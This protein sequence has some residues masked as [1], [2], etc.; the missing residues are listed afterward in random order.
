MS[1][2]SA[3]AASSSLPTTISTNHDNPIHQKKRIAPLASSPT[4]QH[5]PLA[6][7]ISTPRR[8]AQMMGLSTPKLSIEDGDDDTMEEKDLTCCG[9]F[10]LNEFLLVYLALA[11]GT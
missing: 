8:L 10:P 1:S 7:A 9:A 3:A 6:V 11:Y 5:A 2:S 4:N